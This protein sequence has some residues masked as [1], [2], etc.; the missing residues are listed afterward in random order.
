MNSN[1]LLV[2]TLVSQTA[3]RTRNN[4]LCVEM[5]AYRKDPSITTLILN[6]DTTW[7]TVVSFTTRHNTRGKKNC[8]YPLNRN[9]IWPQKFSGYYGVEEINLAPLWV[10]FCTGMD[11][12]CL[13]MKFQ[14]P[15]PKISSVLKH[16]QIKIKYVFYVPISHNVKIS[17]KR[18]YFSKIYKNKILHQ[19]PNLSQQM[20]P[21]PV[22]FIVSD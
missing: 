8:K 16:K 10:K 14:R 21:S 12:I 6:T 1:I 22:Q 2:A 9:L 19:D 7:G 15:V 5:K 3:L 11:T 20:S 4:G 17:T 13:H 18:S